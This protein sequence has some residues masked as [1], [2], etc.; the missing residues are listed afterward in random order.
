MNITLLHIDGCPNWIEAES[1]LVD[2][3]AAVG[4]AG[5]PVKVIT[6]TDA[7]QA[8]GLNFAGSPTIL[9]NGT[10]LFADGTRVGD[11]AC[12]IYRTPAGIAGSPTT[13]QIVQA[14]SAL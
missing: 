10:D 9:V 11:L 7:T 12:R 1:R 3:L 5:A 8:A 14:L 4:K 2:A 13:D 6:V